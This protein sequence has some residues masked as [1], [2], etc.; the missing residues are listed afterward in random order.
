AAS[1]RPPAV[2]CCDHG[3]SG[4][5]GDRHGLLGKPV[6]DRHVLRGVV[7]G[8]RTRVSSRQVRPGAQITVTADYMYDGCNDTGRH[9]RLPPLRH[10]AVRWAQDGHPVVLAWVDANPAGRAAAR[11]TVPFAASPGRATLQLGIATRV[12]LNVGRGHSQE[13]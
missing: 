11:V 13:T 7:R 3:T 9:V 6:A 12:T 10:Q 2:V 4:S 8:P 1:R 5:R